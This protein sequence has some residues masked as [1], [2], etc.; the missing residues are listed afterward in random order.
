MSLSASFVPPVGAVSA[1]DRSGTVRSPA[2]LAY[3][4]FDP[5]WTLGVTHF[6]FA[7]RLFM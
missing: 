1:P 6:R 2:R 7:Q 5:F 4:G 3:A